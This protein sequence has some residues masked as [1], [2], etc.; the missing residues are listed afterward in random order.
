VLGGQCVAPDEPCPSLDV[1]DLPHAAYPAGTMRQPSST[2]VSRGLLLVGLILLALNLR[3][4]AVSVGPILAE[5]VSGLSMGPV[6]AGLL[7]SL[8]VL[9]FATFGAGAP[10]L[11]RRVGVHRATLLAIAAL[12]VGLSVRVT[13][14]SAVPFLLWS[15]LALSGMAAANVLLPSL[16]KLHFP[17]RIGLLTALYT[18]ALAV[19]LTVSLVATVPI[20]EAAGDWRVGL[21]A[22]AVLGLLAALP[23]LRLAAHDR[24]LDPDRHEIRLADVARTR[25][26][27]A[28]ALL[29]GLQSTQAYV[30]FGWFAQLWRDAGFSAAEAGVLIGVVGAVQIPFSVLLPILAGRRR[31]HRV[32]LW[33]VMACYPVGYVGLMLT[34]YSLAVLWALVVG[35]GVS[36][37]PLVLTLIGLRAR[38]PAG[39]AALSGFTQSA[40]YLLSAAGPFTVGLLYHATGEWIAPLWFVTALVLPM[41]LLAAYVGRPRYVEDQLPE[42][43][44]AP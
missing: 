4:A 12:V 18:T 43:V 24:H 44:T 31:D 42:L 14:D 6:S 38:T 32:L 2:A 21:A 27:V 30:T 28:M 26:G 13:V 15:M 35:A 17:T 3:P 37:F 36:T 25:L 9:A 33:A 22:W 34:P 41:M 39:T 5:V 29:F 40:G 11:A 1:R 8:P 10:L 19:G 7:T 20:A 23:W 16:V